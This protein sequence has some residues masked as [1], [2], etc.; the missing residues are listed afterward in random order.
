MNIFK[1]ENKLFKEN[2]EE[3]ENEIREWK[4][5]VKELETAI[6]GKN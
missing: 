5:K 4:L 3:K 2:L 1:A 6:D